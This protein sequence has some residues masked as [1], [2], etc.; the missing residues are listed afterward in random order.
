MYRCTGCTRLAIATKSKI[1]KNRCRVIIP[2]ICSY[3]FTFFFFLPWKLRGQTISGSLNAPASRPEKSF[4]ITRKTHT[5]NSVD[6]PNLKVDNLKKSISRV[7]NRR[8]Y[9][10]I[11]QETTLVSSRHCFVI[12]FFYVITCIL[13]MPGM[14][15]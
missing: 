8:K 12:F 13:I 5:S 2:G 4:R 9:L 15:H 6:E 11:V 1:A 14:F 3:F 7:G 10:R